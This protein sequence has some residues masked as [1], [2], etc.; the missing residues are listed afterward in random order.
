MWW[1][2]EATTRNISKISL[3]LTIKK[4]TNYHLH[5]YILYLI[6]KREF[7]AIFNL[8]KGK[9]TKQQKKIIINTVLLI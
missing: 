6:G 9:T 4:G 2:E 5:T 7:F 3:Y 8:G 1:I